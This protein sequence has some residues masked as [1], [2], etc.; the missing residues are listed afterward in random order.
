MLEAFFLESTG[1]RPILVLHVAAWADPG[2]IPNTEYGL[3]STATGHSLTQIQ[4][5]SNGIGKHG[6]QTQKSNM[7]E[8]ELLELLQAMSL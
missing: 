5:L 8:K 1:V 2:S 4:E 6:L 7:P 3:L